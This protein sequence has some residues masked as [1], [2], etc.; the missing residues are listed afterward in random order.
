MKYDGKK[1]LGVFLRIATGFFASRAKGEATR[2]A[3]KLWTTSGT[4]KGNFWREKGKDRE[5]GRETER[6]R[7]IPRE[8]ERERGREIERHRER[9]GRRERDRGKERQRERGRER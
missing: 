3:K 8:G 1:F 4:R 7:E 9:D 2:E 5:R 6:H